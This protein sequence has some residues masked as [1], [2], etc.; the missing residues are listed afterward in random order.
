M[1]VR[2]YPDW[3]EAFERIGSWIQAGDLAYRES[4][5]DGFENAPN[6][7]LGLFKGDNI[8]KQVVRVGERS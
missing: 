5:V 2:D 4:V 7:F 6:A 1:L 8:G 3:T